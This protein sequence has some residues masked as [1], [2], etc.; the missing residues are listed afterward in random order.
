MPPDGSARS[1]NPVR[2]GLVG[3]GRWG[4]NVIRTLQQD[5][6]AKLTAVASGNPDT[7]TL[8]GDDCAVIGQWR[9]LLD[10]GRIDGVVL[11]VP[12]GAQPA[13]AEAA[14]ARGLPLLLEKPVA[15]GIAEAEALLAAARRQSALVQVDHTDLSNPAF[16]AMAA[17]LPAAGTVLSLEGTW[18][19]P[20]PYRGDIAGFWDY[21]SH[22]MADCLTLMGGDPVDCVVLES[23]SAGAGELV[24]A[25][26]RWPGGAVGRITAGNGATDKCRRLRVVCT[27][28]S[29]EF[30]D[31]A[32]DKASM[33]G[34]P[35]S[36]DRRAMPLTQALHRFAN[37]AAVGRPDV[38]DLELGVR[39]V[40]V[41]QRLRPA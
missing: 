27:D 37:A 1:A 17:A 5:G 19:G 40:R 10:S 22:A 18:A 30:D 12:T 14:L 32:A 20:G 41:L 26:L 34:K 28:H 24:T 33:D 38:S 3:A 15:A 35:L 23:R 9:D 36:Y 6:P 16:T 25:E 8:V 11:A 21:G 29:L 7:A 2:L 39:V 31:L 13:I 4:R